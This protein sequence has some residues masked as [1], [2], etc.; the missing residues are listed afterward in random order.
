MSVSPQDW[1]RLKDMLNKAYHEGQA[2]QHRA[3]VAVPN[4]PEDPI[5]VLD[6][7]EREVLEWEDREDIPQKAEVLRQIRYA[8]KAVSDNDDGE[9]KY[10]LFLMVKNNENYQ[11]DLREISLA[12][13]EIKESRGGAKGGAAPKRK[14]WAELAAEKLADVAASK[15]FTEEQAWKYLAEQAESHDPWTLEKGLEEW[16]FYCD[17]SKVFAKY[18]D[19]E[20][21]TETLKK[22]SFL[23]NYYRKAKKG[24]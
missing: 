18:A 5:A 20:S 2:L 4:L 12:Q 7:W 14:P 17:G 23:K 10:R 9:L 16:E 22:S 15:H 3:Q 19:G 21:R 1:Q 8:R 13:R 11:H 6:N 24:G